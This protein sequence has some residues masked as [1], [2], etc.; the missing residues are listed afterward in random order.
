MNHDD[1]KY[2]QQA[3][4][5]FKQ[6]ILSNIANTGRVSK[7]FTIPFPEIEAGTGR[8]HIDSTLVSHYLKY[9]EEEG[10][11]AEF[12]DG[13]RIIVTV[14]LGT[15]LLSPSEAQALSDARNCYQI[16]QV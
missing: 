5:S 11:D 6:Y 14:D 4:Y 10:M 7:T 9:L 8:E 16:K 13:L 15:L 12:D 2:I 3:I 1:L